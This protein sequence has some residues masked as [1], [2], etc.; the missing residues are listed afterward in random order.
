VADHAE[1]RI[2]FATARETSVIPRADEPH[3]ISALKRLRPKIAKADARACRDAQRRRLCRRTS[4]RLPFKVWRVPLARIRTRQQRNLRCLQ[5]AAIE[6]HR[7]DIAHKVATEVRRGAADLENMRLHIWPRKFL[8]R[9]DCLAIEVQ[10]RD[11]VAQNHGRRVPRAIVYLR[12]TR[13]RAQPANVIDEPSVTH[14]KRLCIRSP[15]SFGRSHRCQCPARRR[16][17]ARDER[18]VRIEA[19]FL[20]RPLDRRNKARSRRFVGSS[21]R[22]LE[23]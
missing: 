10:R 2:N 23:A 21:H 19:Q 13:E 22:H 6:T 4:L 18:E 3:V 20:S 16:A 7:G 14:E 1:L 11:A 9:S 17:E 15:F 5:S 8:A 12:S